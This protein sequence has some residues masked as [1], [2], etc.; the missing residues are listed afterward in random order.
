MENMQIEVSPRTVLRI[1]RDPS[2]LQHLLEQSNLMCVNQDPSEITTQET[3]VAS[4]II[5]QET[6][7]NVGGSSDSL[8]EYDA[9]EGTSQRN[10]AE[11]PTWD[12]AAVKLLISS[13]EEIRPSVGKANKYKTKQ[14]MWQEIQERLQSY[15]YGFTT[16]QISN[17]FLKLEQSYK[18]TK[19]HNSKTGR[20]RRSCPYE[21]ELDG[22]LKNTAAVNA[23]HTVDA[24]GTINMENLDPECSNDKPGTS[25]NTNEDLDTQKERSRRNRKDD[26]VN[27]LRHIRESNEAFQDKVL[28]IIENAEQQK[29]NAMEARNALFEKFINKL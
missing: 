9:Y 17:K 5:F 15:G 12:E 6:I 27:E 7:A 18:Q 26:I 11:K 23:F 2:V 24:S 10:V 22:M 19:D 14:K 16:K 3:E 29:I 28:E 13:V 25:R 4:P 20:D 8:I 21:K 1:Q